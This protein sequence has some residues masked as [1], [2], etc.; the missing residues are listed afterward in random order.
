MKL[1]FQNVADLAANGPAIWRAERKVPIPIARDR[2]SEEPACRAGL[3]PD[4]S[5]G[6]SPG[7]LASFA[8]RN[9][10]SREGG[11]AVTVQGGYGALFA[12][13]VQFLLSI[14]RVAVQVLWRAGHKSKCKEF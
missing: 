12:V 13:M 5:T 7:T 4:A 14:I 9:D 2:D 1:R 11:K 10:F 8:H 3:L 6:L